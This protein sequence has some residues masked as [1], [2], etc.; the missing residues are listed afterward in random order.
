[1]S[2]Q[3]KA[4]RARECWPCV[5]R[6]Y[7]SRVRSSGPARVNAASTRDPVRPDDLTTLGL[8]RV[9]HCRDARGLRPN[10]RSG[11]RCRRHIVLHG[12]ILEGME[13]L[14]ERVHARP[15]VG[16]SGGAA[17]GLAGSRPELLECVVNAVTL[18]VQ[19]C[20]ALVEASDALALRRRPV[21]AGHR[22][23]ELR[24]LNA[25]V[26]DHARRW[27]LRC[28]WDSQDERSEGRGG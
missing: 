14:H 22:E 28:G 5:R 21:D 23:T 20:I 16:G 18:R 7:A 8:E 13:V 17:P 15:G 25:D 19:S 9:D 26:C 24:Q 10:L 27:G 11:G 1:M 2:S 12:C 6:P 3:R 4:H